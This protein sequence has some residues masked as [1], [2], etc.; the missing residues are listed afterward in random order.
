MALFGKKENENSCSAVILA[1]G[2]SLRM[3]EDKSMMMLGNMPVLVRAIDA[4][5]QCGLIDEIIVVTKMDKIESVA[6]LCKEHNL[7]KVKKVIAGGS[8]R[9]ESSL[10]GVS[11][12]SRKAKLIAIHDAARPLVSQKLIKNGIYTAAEFKSA[13][14]AIPSSDTLRIK[15]NDYIGAFI[16]RDSV[17]RI[18]TPQIFAADVIKGAL[19]KAVEKK[20]QLTDD[21]SALASIGFKIRLYEG[22]PVNI[23]L[24]VPTDL[25]IAE[26]LLK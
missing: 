11:A 26:A 9:M 21:A 2:D 1:A 6:D 17:V 22:D 10:A 7:S 13:V 14:P 12:V 4:F 15:D 3:G 18:Q 24:T 25:I 20:L 23:K 19:T 8:N 16:D 5:Q